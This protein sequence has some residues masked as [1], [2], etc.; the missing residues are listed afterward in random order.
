MRNRDELARQ[1][2]E[3]MTAINTAIKDSDEKGFSVAF[4]AYTEMLQDAVMAEAK[5]LVSA[6]D[7]HVLIGRGVRTLTSK[8]TEYYQKLIGAMR[9]S[10][11]KQELT[12]LAEGDYRH[13]LPE[14]II[15]AVFEDIT[16]SHPLLS[17][18]NFQNTSVLVKYLYS[19]M[20]N[21]HLATWGALCSDLGAGLQAEFKMLSLEQT[22][23]SAIVP[24]CKAMLDLGPAWLDR[25]VR[26]IL[27][28]SVA[29][30]LENGIINGLGYD[31][32]P[33]PIISQPIGMIR[34]IT[35][36]INTGHGYYAQS[37]IPITNF[38]PEVYLPLVANLVKVPIP[39]GDSRVSD[40]YR[41]VT[42]VTLIVN[43]VD[44]LTKIIPAT[45]HKQPDGKYVSEIFPFPT[46]VVQSAYVAANRAILGLP[47][48]YLMAMGVGGSGGH[49][50]YSDDVR[51]LE[52]ER[53]YA[54]KLYGT[55]RPID[56]NSF[57]Y[58]DITNVEPVVK[59]VR[60]TELPEWPEYPAWPEWP[61]LPEWGDTTLQAL[62]FGEKDDDPEELTPAFSHVK[63]QYTVA[64]ITSADGT[65]K[66]EVEGTPADDDDATVEYTLNGAE[67]VDPTEFSL[68][69]GLNTIVI[70]VTNG[71]MSRNYIIIVEYETLA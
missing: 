20:D 18:I 69:D 59:P 53:V 14:T 65:E 50:E 44:Y 6:A 4:E 66:Y 64:K 16:E 48:R 25:Y 24:V 5:G 34:D 17:I 42:E 56:A 63:Y 9:S 23:L 29:N 3:I 27:A 60:V 10:N 41:P 45:I 28:E 31:D 30:G 46:R 15:D 71:K 40:L 33:S 57:I 47:E 1:K 37:A 43:P 39:K 49:I 68:V 51:F 7:N 11:P 58:L 35:R 22:K 61:A 12:E 55:G 70:T 8:E 13:V 19:T 62:T 54:I 26:T 36:G 32:N 2:A 67:L 52:D 38:G 21:R